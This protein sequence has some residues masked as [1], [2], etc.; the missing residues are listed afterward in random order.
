LSPTSQ[1]FFACVKYSA[2]FAASS[3][4][5]CEVGVRACSKTARKASVA[6]SFAAQ[7]VR[8]FSDAT[9]PDASVASGVDE[10]RSFDSVARRSL[11]Q[12]R[13]VSAAFASSAS[14]RACRYQRVL[15]SAA[16]E[17]MIVTIASDVAA[18]SMVAG[19][20]EGAGAE[21]VVCVRDRADRDLSRNSTM[22]WG[23]CQESEL[24]PPL[25]CKP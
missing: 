15:G 12:G 4:L 20:R 11:S 3:A 17:L 9:K 2:R 25:K 8:V 23:C 13:T 21:D 10:A 22:D 1:A 5:S 7:N 14:V 16:G 18:K 6:A 19:A 24:S